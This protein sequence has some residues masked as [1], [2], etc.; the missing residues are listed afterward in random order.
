MTSCLIINSTGSVKSDGELGELVLLADERG[1]PSR[2]AMVMSLAFRAA[3]GH[4][5]PMVY[6]PLRATDRGLCLSM[7][8]ES[9]ASPLDRLEDAETRDELVQCFLAQRN[10]PSLNDRTW[11]KK[12][13]E[14]AITSPSPSPR[15]IRCRR[16]SSASRLVLRTTSG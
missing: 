5:A 2:S 4:E 16:F 8:P 15:W 12:W 11:A 9:A 1:V 3:L 6:E 10:L 7:L 14:P 13:T